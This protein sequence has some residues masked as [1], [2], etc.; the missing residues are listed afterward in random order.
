MTAWLHVV[1]LGEDG[2]D[3]LGPEARARIAAAEVLV[4]S[5]RHHALVPDSRA[6]RLTWATP[7]SRTIADILACRGR[8]V[9]VL[10]TGDPLWYGIGVTLQRHLDAGELAVLPAVGA[11]SLAAARLG[12]PL[13]ET[14][15]LTLHG[16]P[17][18][19]LARY[20]AP[21]QRL[22]LLSHDG[23]T[24]AHVAARLAGLGYGPSP[25]TVFE[26]LGGPLERRLDGTAAAWPHGAAAALNTIAVDCRP[27]SG[28]RPLPAIPGL[29]DDAFHHDGQL[30]KSLVRAAALARLA[31]LP[32]QRLW[33]VGAGAGS[34]AIE[35]LRAAAR[36]AAIAV[37]RRAE[38]IAMIQANAEALGVPELTVVA[39]AAPAALAGLPPPDAVFVGG[40]LTEPGLIE[41]CWAAL[42]AGGRLVAHAVTVEGEA[43]LAAALGR[44]GGGLTRLALTE[45]RP[46]GRRLAWR[47]ALPVTQWTIV[48]S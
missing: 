2:L 12:W 21:G 17:L 13:A 35:W 5:A 28:A 36:T 7:L 3:G 37:E 41:A 4:G 33:D 22:L 40:G 11:F 31:P 24:P 30:T 43:T 9:V 18:A 44:W 1:G 16:R 32:G 15:C 47:P 46:L 29:P 26:H 25:M 14:L 23:T 19:Q 42:P 8:P 38:R 27:A 20:A 39:G 10:A 48:K 34:V 6:E 45:A